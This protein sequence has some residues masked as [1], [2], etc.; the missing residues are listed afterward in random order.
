MSTGLHLL[1]HS[2]VAKIHD[3]NGYSSVYSRT[4]LVNTLVSDVSDPLNFVDMNLPVITAATQ[5][6]RGL[7]VEENT[8]EDIISVVPRLITIS[9]PNWCGRVRQIDPRLTPMVRAK[10]NGI[11]IFVWV[12]VLTLPSLCY[13]ISVLLRNL[14][15]ISPRGYLHWVAGIRLNDLLTELKTAAPQIRISD[16]LV[17]FKQKAND[18]IA[19]YVALQTFQNNEKFVT[20]LESNFV[21]VLIKDSWL[22][23]FDELLTPSLLAPAKIDDKNLKKWKIYFI[24]ALFDCVVLDSFKLEITYIDTLEL[25]L[26]HAAVGLQENKVE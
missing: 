8:V 13:L 18:V 7:C 14:F 2:F 6:T 19:E 26:K 24:K 21:K 22:K 12:I 23:L 20:N 25:G 11:Y 9:D 1:I 17:A 4:P 15:F 10:I 16:T 5:L 3:I